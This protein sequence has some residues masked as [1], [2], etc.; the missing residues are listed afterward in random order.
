M[1]I[2]AG[3]E[4]DQGV[5]SYEVRLVMERTMYNIYKY[6]KWVYVRG[7]KCK[8]LMVTELWSLRLYQV[9]GL[10]CNVC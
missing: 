4:R 8:L 7:S 3:F 10:E 9:G 6:C 5:R 1:A 2:A